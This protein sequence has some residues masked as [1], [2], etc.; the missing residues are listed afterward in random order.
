MTVEE[1]LLLAGV[2]LVGAL[3]LSLLAAFWFDLRLK[4]RLP[5]NR[6][7]TWGFFFGCLCIACCVPLAA[8]SGLETVRAALSG[9]WAACEIHAIYS[10]L[11]GLSAI[12][13]WG[14]VKRKGWAWILGTLLGPISAFPVLRDFLGHVL[15]PAGFLG[16]IILLVNYL[17]GRKRWSEFHLPAPTPAPADS[18]LA[19]PI[20]PEPTPL[21]PLS[22]GAPAKRPSAE[23]ALVD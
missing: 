7:Y 11:F 2:Y 1:V 13:G 3:I 6:P 23:P 14:I 19:E 12:C 18:K 20:A 5:A 8:V 9:K 22:P 21:L 15:A 16:C 10:L 17:Y 4:A